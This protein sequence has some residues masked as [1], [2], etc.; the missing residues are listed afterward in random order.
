MSRKD[1]VSFSLFK[2]EQMC[3]HKSIKPK[4]GIPW[5]V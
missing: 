5:T 2:C 1:I 3:Y 4:G